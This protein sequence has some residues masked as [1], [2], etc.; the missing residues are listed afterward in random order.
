MRLDGSA[1]EGQ[2]NAMSTTAHA[3]GAD[4]RRLLRTLDRA[5]LAT[6]LD[7]W[8]YAS[9]VLAAAAPDASPVLLLSGLAQHTKNLGAEPRASLLFDGTGGLDDPLT[10]PRVT[11]L[12]RLDRCDDSRLRARFVAR[13]PS[14]ALYAGFGDFALYRLAVER[15]HLVAGFGR[16]DWVAAPELLF[17]AAPAEALVSAEPDIVAHMND[18]HAEAVELY[19]TRL[20]G[21]R[22][23]RWRMTGIDPEGIDLRLAGEVARLGFEA[24]VCDAGGARAALVRLAEAARRKG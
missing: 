16:I 12:G 8:P 2:I 23:G 20:L 3:T 13:H 22:G 17:D 10:G 9:L 1:R 7:G 5:S 15:A 14:A 21:R 4:A 6:S 11:V 18:D 24:P 19:A